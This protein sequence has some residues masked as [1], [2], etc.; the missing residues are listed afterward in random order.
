MMVL[1]DRV[2]T[3]VR[4]LSDCK[5][6]ISQNVQERNV[7]LERIKYLEGK[8]KNDEAHIQTNDKELK[9]LQK[10]KRYKT[11]IN[12][13]Q[14][15]IKRQKRDLRLARYLNKRLFEHYLKLYQNT[16][17]GQKAGLKVNFKDKLTKAKSPS[18]KAENE[19]FNEMSEES[20]ED[21]LV[22]PQKVRNAIWN[23][24][25]PN[26]NNKGSQEL[27]LRR[28]NFENK[29]R[30]E[31][32]GSLLQSNA[33]KAHSTSPCSKNSIEDD[34][35]DD[36]QSEVSLPE[37]PASLMDLL[38]FDKTPPKLSTSPLGIE[39]FKGLNDQKALASK[40]L[41][42]LY[43]FHETL[44]EIKSRRHRRGK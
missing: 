27:E 43:R 14:K 7:L 42:A 17:H 33:K 5:E 26:A 11:K 18:C 21:S 15:F 8:S 37:T 32:G 34:D 10:A 44:K 25:R 16:K 20:S 40:Q 28:R 1:R 38:T 30:R 35:K 3:M 31:I 13:L 24:K 22:I 9:W 19:V 29:E 39:I 23:K 12:H 2:R 41:D 4:L 36:G 6:V